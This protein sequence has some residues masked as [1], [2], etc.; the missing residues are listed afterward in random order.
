MNTANPIVISIWVALVPTSTALLSAQSVVDSEDTLAVGVVEMINRHEFQAAERNIYSQLHRDSTSLKWLFLMGMRYYSDISLLPGQANDALSHMKFW[1]EKVTNLG[2]A[3]IEQDEADLEA[4]FYTGGAYG[5]LGIAYASDGSLLKGVSTSAKGF[6]MHEDLTELCPE[7]YDAYLG[8]GL[9]NFVASAVPWILKPILLVLGLTGTEEKAH[10]YLL[11]AYER[12]ILVRLEAGIYLA[13]LYLRQKEY[14][15]AIR[16]YSILV[17]EYPMRVGLCVEAMQPFYPTERFAEMIALAQNT[18]RMFESGRFSLSAGDSA[19]MPAIIDHCANGFEAVGD[20]AGAIGI[21]EQ[22]LQKRQYASLDK[23]RIYRSLGDLYLQ[24]GDTLRSLACYE[25]VLTSNA[26]EKTK[27][28]TRDKIK[29]IR[30][31]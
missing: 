26:P 5:Y 29:G 13:Q 18:M 11:T 6:G 3:R 22:A 8:P 1:M 30:G 27:N 4:L 28:R 7:C 9:E 15:K 20:T 24:Q 25:K 31:Y 19:W 2:D 21:L 10:A 12:G 14:E 17:S 23:E 16:L